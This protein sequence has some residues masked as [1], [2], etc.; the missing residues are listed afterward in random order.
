[1][2]ALLTLVSLSACLFAGA[3]FA[4]DAQCMQG[5]D[6]IPDV[7]A[8]ACSKKAG[9]NSGMCKAKCDEAA[10]KCKDNCAKRNP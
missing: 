1:M 4:T 9:G 6:Q 3:A 10:K 2:K 7:C 5:C 8:K